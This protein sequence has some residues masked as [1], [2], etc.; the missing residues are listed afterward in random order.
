MPDTVTLYHNPRCGK[1]RSAL[2]LL[3][4]RGADVTVVEYLKS[5]LTRAELAALV[6]KLGIPAGALV[7]KGEAV[8]QEHYGHRTM[9][10]DTWLDA[11]ATHP[12]LMERPVAVRGARAVIG[13]PP[14]NV[15][16]LL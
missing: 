3:Q 11:M 4:E 12:I 14:E 6:Q 10:D 2:A 5:P 8:C 1:S 15:L 16:Q 7:R 9:T 13:R